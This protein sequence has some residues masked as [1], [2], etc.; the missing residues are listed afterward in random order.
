MADHNLFCGSTSFLPL[1]FSYCH[2]PLGPFARITYVS[3]LALIAAHFP[4]LPIRSGLEPMSASKTKIG[5]I[6]RN[7]RPATLNMISISILGCPLG[8][9]GL[10]PDRIRFIQ[11]PV[12]ISTRF[13]Q[14][15]LNGGTVPQ[16]AESSDANDRKR[17]ARRATFA[18]L[19]ETFT[20]PDWNPHFDVMFLA[21]A[22]RPAN[23][24]AYFSRT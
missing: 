7:L 10:N 6:Y 19:R 12:R 15:S 2:F 9:K 3:Y 4:P 8:R 18:G 17:Q 23:L 24:P 20:Q 16:N 22:L 1:L 14:N 11:C 13:M 5:R 21:R